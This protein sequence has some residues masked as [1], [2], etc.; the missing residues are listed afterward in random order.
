MEML[1]RKDESKFEEIGSVN[2]QYNEAR[3]EIAK[4][5]EQIHVI[6][7]DNIKLRTALVTTEMRYDDLGREFKMY[8]SNLEQAHEA[9]LLV[10]NSELEQA[11][12]CLRLI[13]KERDEWREKEESLRNDLYFLKEIN[14][15]S[16]EITRTEY[17]QKLQDLRLEHCKT[18]ELLSSA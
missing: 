3:N 2:S 16:H 17:E 4:L 12:K 15:K 13:E 5:Q 18:L 14:I 6:N 9:K 7:T 1:K 10:K 8:K 11:R